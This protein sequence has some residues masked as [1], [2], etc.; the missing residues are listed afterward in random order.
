MNSRHSESHTARAVA[1]GFAL[2]LFAELGSSP[3]LSG[4]APQPET[5]RV[6]GRVLGNSDPAQPL[7]G[8]LITV[9]GSMLKMDRI[10]ITDEMGWFELQDLPVGRVTVTAAKHGWVTSVY[11]AR[12]IGG[13]GTPIDLIHGQ[14]VQL[15]IR[16]QR[17]G[18]LTG[19]I[20]DVNGD[21]APSLIVFAIGARQQSLRIEPRF[22]RS[23]EIPM[24]VTDDRGRYRLFDVAPGDYYIVAFSGANI[25]ASGIDAPSVQEI[26]AILAML[27]NRATPPG[28]PST[29]RPSAALHVRRKQLIAPVFFPGTARRSDAAVTTLAAGEERQGLDFIV[30]PVPLV[31][32]DGYVVGAPGSRIQLGITPLDGLGAFG[33][34]E[35]NPV[36][37][38]GPDQGGH[39]RYSVVPG[40]YRLSAQSVAS[41]GSG[42]ILFGSADVDVYGEDVSAIAIT[43]RQP[44]LASG[45]VVFDSLATTAPPTPTDCRIDVVAE[46]DSRAGIAGGVT[47]IGSALSPPR[48]VTPQ[49]TGR[50]TL[51][52]LPPGRYRLEVTTA[53]VTRSGWW[54][55]SAI[56]SGRDVLDTGLEISSADSDILLV[57]TMTDRLNELKGTLLGISGLPAPEYHVVVFPSD[58]ALRRP[59]SRR[60]RL[61]RPSTGGAYSFDR[62][63]AGDYIVAALTDAPENDWE[64]PEF[65]AALAPFG[66][67]VVMNDG[68]PTI[69]NIQVS[70]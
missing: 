54:L 20:R 31:A 40:R 69:Q 29:S 53:P 32:I 65:L 16:L 1:V 15:E 42:D 22:G 66:V 46:T 37:T 64:Q 11:G 60:V 14:R 3:S 2:L 45:R 59:K 21:P 13:S 8:A 58:P 25:S 33:L 36:L 7:R 49:V 17:S 34:G 44:P 41:T 28:P 38:D 39:F 4:Q 23:S 57:L 10:A 47:R 67:R 6:V 62:L 61:T 63:P 18:V 12:T 27:Q 5:T 55:R 56:W 30:T 51:G 9:K 26:D 68:S 70:R 52:R 24:A 19:V 43:L 35:G 50:F 48:S